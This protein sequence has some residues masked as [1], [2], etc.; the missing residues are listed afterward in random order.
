M[1][2]VSTVSQVSHQP[3]DEIARL[4]NE[5][6]SLGRPLHPDEVLETLDRL[7]K[8]PGTLESYR[9]FDE[10]TYRRN[11][12]FRNEFVDVLLLCWRPSQRT[13]IHDH[14]GSTC[15]VLVLEGQG[16]EV[17]F[18]KTGVGLLIPSQVSTIS[19]GDLSVCEDTDVH[20]VGNFSAEQGDLVTLHCYSPPLTKMRTYQSGETFLADYDGVVNR[21]SATACYHT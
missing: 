19:P 13:P 3:V 8:M 16:T 4:C 10:S 6:E 14:A 9:K 7:S 18:D 21:A 17:T 2:T 15:G 12:I 5:L 20:M 11:R 1:E